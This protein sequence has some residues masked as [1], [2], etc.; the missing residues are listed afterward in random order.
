MLS[1]CIE[2][3]ASIWNF[4]A[5]PA[6]V[7]IITKR[8]LRALPIPK[9]I[10]V[11]STLAWWFHAALLFFKYKAPIALVTFSIF[12][13]ELFTVGVRLLAF[14]FFVEEISVCALDTLFIL[15]LVAIGITSFLGWKQSLGKTSIF[16][17]NEARVAGGASP[18]FLIIVEAIGV[19]W[20]TDSF[21]IFVETRGATSARARGAE[22]LAATIKNN[23][24]GGKCECEEGEND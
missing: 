10:T 22:L 7:K 4:L 2:I 19:D 3:S 9:F 16:Y 23:D 13:L 17:H 24:V 18:C 5:F 14:P 15:K 12:F 8:A 1:V 11:V 21:L 6:G 20:L